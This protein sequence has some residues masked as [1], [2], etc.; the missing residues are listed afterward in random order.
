[1]P[2]N[3]MMIL[4]GLGMAG[5]WFMNRQRGSQEDQV[6]QLTGAS[7][8]ASGEGTAPDAPF[9]PF[10][11]PSDPVFFFNQGGQM[12]KVPGAPIPFAATSGEDIGKHPSGN[13]P[14]E[15]EFEVEKGIPAP[16]TSDD[17]PIN[18]AFSDDTQ[19]V[20]PSTIWN[21]QAAIAVANE[22]PLLA[23]QDAKGGGIEILGSNVDIATL[24]S[25]EQFR[26]V[27][28]S[29]PTGDITGGFTT[30]GEVLAEYVK[31]FNTSAAGPSAAP[32]RPPVPVA[33][34][35]D[36]DIGF[37]PTTSTTFGGL[38]S[39]GELEFEVAR[40]VP[41]AGTTDISPTTPQFAGL[42]AVTV[43]PATIWDAFANEWESF[44]PSAR[45]T[46]IGPGV[47]SPDTSGLAL[48]TSD[49]A[50]IAIG[51]ASVPVWA[52]GGDWWGEG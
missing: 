48:G 7:M 9:Q 6:D 15:L 3:N 8:M 5:L 4:M 19:T 16:G 40:S 45:E 47:G 37:Y 38:Y 26:A 28:F 29:D 49:A 43:T 24:S 2:T 34:T 13:N 39:P 44:G 14:P 52:A 22:M 10:S 35:S 30:T 51:E 31:G 27:S 42:A 12:T 1:M 17:S 46:I 32:V 20:F 23:I 33:S 18:P 25:K 36:E 41:P 21:D 50:K 11:G